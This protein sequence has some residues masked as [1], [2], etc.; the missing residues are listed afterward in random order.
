[1]D[2]VQSLD[3]LHNC[4][5]ESLR[6][7]PPLIMLMRL[8]HTPLRVGKFTVPVGHYVFAPL[9]VSMNLPDS[10]PDAV[11]KAPERYDPDRYAADR[12]GGKEDARP[13]TFCA[14]GGGKHGCLGEQF[15][16]LQVKTI[17]SMIL[18]RYELQPLG[19]LPKPNFKAM[20]VGPLQENN[21]CRVR[22]RRRTTPLVG[23]P[24]F[25]VGVGAGVGAGAGA[26][27]AAARA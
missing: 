19:P 27:A 23:S 16:Y 14:F 20:V 5:K 26:S 2:N 11:F 17:V 6:Q 21:A 12:P 8:V 15:G 1:M 4:M 13:F 18:R 22:Y 9:A 24:A 7:Y 3:F 25:A 10:A